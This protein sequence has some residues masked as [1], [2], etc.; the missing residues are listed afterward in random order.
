MKRTIILGMTVLMTTSAVN[1]DESKFTRYNLSDH[2]GAIVEEAVRDGLK[3]P[4]SARFDKVEAT[5]SEENGVVVCGLVNAKNSFG[6]YEGKS[7]F[8]GMLVNDR[9][10]KTVFIVLTSGSSKAAIQVTSAAC[11]RNE[12]TLP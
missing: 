4:E 7:P 6:G 10:G 2:E 1:A 11:A 8:M 3:D 5:S 9:A 12:I